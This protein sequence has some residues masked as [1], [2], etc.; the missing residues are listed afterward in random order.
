M[1]GSI[2][3]VSNTRTADGLRSSLHRKRAAPTHPDDR[4]APVIGSCFG[5]IVMR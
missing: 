2:V 5:K 3:P 4:L 1:T